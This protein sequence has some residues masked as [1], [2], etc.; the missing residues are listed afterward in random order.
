MS[1]DP[2]NNKGATEK[3]VI[4]SD[5]LS[6]RNATKILNRFSNEHHKTSVQRNQF[7]LSLFVER[8]FT[9]CKSR[10]ERE[11]IAGPLAERVL[12]ESTNW[13]CTYLA[14][15][16]ALGSMSPDKLMIEL[17]RRLIDAD[18]LSIVARATY[19]AEFE[20]LKL[21]RM[22]GG[23]DE[24]DQRSFYLLQ[25]LVNDVQWGFAKMYL[26]RDYVKAYMLRVY[27]IFTAAIVLFLY[28]LFL[29][30]VPEMPVQTSGPVPQL[31]ST[32]VIDTAS[33]GTGTPTTNANMAERWWAALPEIDLL[34]TSGFFL[35]IVSGVLGAAFS[36][37]ALLQKRVQAGTLDDVIALSSWPNLLVRISFGA[38]AAVVL[39]FI[40]Q[41]GLLQ[42]IVFPELPK[43]GFLP[44]ECEEAAA[45]CVDLR[46]N[47]WVPN[48]DLAAL[49]V[50]CFIAGF[51]ES[52]VPSLLDRIQ[53]SGGEK[54]SN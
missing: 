7:T 27:A 38:G 36:I 21:D 25:R 47:G 16:L 10:P 37:L 41:A 15:Q 33:E 11:R 43:M 1:D 34:G 8:I 28:T 6:E 4:S 31:D 20:K 35:A 32:E 18:A 46:S 29:E 44:F 40:F 45:G 51:S 3:G 53:E 22:D 17:E 48:Q 2:A 52:F 23:N 49:V 9:D 5:V 14:E 42:G 54:Q 50:W 26:K 13:R 12:A 24:T 30:A 39:Y 19:R